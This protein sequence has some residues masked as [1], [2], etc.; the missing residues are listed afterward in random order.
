MLKI[1]PHK[2]VVSLIGVILAPL[3]LVVEFAELGALDAMLYGTPPR[4]FAPVEQ[5]AMALGIARGVAFLHHHNVVHRDLAARNIVIV[6][7]LIHSC[8]CRRFVGS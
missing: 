5:R 6:L 8:D 1:P 2:N 7:G 4:V 3:A